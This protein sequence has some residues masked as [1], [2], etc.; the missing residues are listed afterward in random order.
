[1][2]PCAEGI[3]KALGLPQSHGERKGQER[4]GHSELKIRERSAGAVRHLQGQEAEPYRHLRGG[5][6][7]REARHQR[8]L[9]L[10]RPQEAVA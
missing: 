7:R 4:G 1:M 5:R 6:G 3:N 2:G 10:R 9:T 8:I